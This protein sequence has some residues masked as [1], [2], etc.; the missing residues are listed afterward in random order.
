MLNDCV[1]GYDGC[2]AMVQCRITPRPL[3]SFPFLQD[4]A[5]L[6]NADLAAG[7]KACALPDLDIIAVDPRWWNANPNISL[8]LWALL[9]EMGHCEGATCEPCADFRA[10]EW[11]R[12]L[13]S[14]GDAK[15]R[16]QVL[17]ALQFRDPAV[18]ERAIHAGFMGQ[19]RPLY[20][21]GSDGETFGLYPT[22][23]FTFWSRGYATEGVL[24]EVR[25]GLWFCAEAA[26]DWDRA[27]TAAELVGIGYSATSSAR[28]M[29]K[30]IDIWNERMWPPYDGSHNRPAKTGLTPAGQVLGEAAYPGWSEHQEGKAADLKF[31]N[32]EDRESFASIAEAYNIRRDVASEGWH[33]AWGGPRRYPLKGD[34][35]G[36]AQA[37]AGEVIDEA[38]GRT[39]DEPPSRAAGTVGSLLVIVLIFAL[40]FFLTRE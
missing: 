9:H 33:F 1:R 2:Q 12:Q 36:N 17:S 22:K 23:P 14:E 28:A 37:K 35:I 29:S 8:R 3:E 6:F 16:A 5:E 27:L 40:V 7:R 10:G 19:G 30:Q 26:P 21:D 31:V 25:P 11:L 32:D 18:A 38:Q 20:A 34:P 15:V 39:G 24:Y 4:G 13:G